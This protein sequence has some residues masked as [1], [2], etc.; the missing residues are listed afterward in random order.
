MGKKNKEKEDLSHWK[1]SFE[2]ETKNP[3]AEEV[4]FYTDE[5]INIKSPELEEE[6]KEY[7]MEAGGEQY[8]YIPCLNYDEKH[9]NFI[10]NLVLKHT[11]GWNIS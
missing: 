11:Q 2:K 9:L 1:K 3:N 5:G 4:F 8:G 10:S 7:F 6:N